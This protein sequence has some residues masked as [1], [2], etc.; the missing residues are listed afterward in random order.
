MSRTPATPRHAQAIRRC[1][2]V[3]MMVGGLF[4]WVGTA[5][6]H[7]EVLPSIAQIGTP[8]EFTVQVPTER[9]LP[10]TSVRVM[11]P[12]RVTVYSFQ[13][14]PPGFTVTPIYASNQSIIGATFR[15]VIPPGQYQHFHFLGTPTALGQTLWPAYQTYADGKVA[16]WT[17][18]PVARGVDPPDTQVPGPTSA[19]TISP[20]S[21]SSQ[22]TSNAALWIGLSA[23]VLAIAALVLA[24][25]GWSR[26]PVHLLDDDTP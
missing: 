11:F 24:G 2:G 15:G 5:T 19:V 13:V 7:V 18:A 26:R 22:T 23:G 1:L 6:A 3:M 21:G 12:S 8:T 4:V 14:P 9:N 10:T 17:G 20:K 16:L 25:L